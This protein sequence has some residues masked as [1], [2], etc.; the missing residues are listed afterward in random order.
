M[1]RESLGQDLEIARSPRARTLNLVAFGRCASDSIDRRVKRPDGFIPE[2]SSGFPNSSR[3]AQE[4]VVRHRISDLRNS[5]ATP[6]RFCSRA[7]QM[8]LL[9][10]LLHASK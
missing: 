7:E 8:L 6:S 1:L 4:H 5:I 10:K 3:A 9:A 2:V